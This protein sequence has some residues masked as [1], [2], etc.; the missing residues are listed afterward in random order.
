[1]NRTGELSTY[2]AR[3]LQGDKK[4]PWEKSKFW[5]GRYPSVRSCIIIILLRVT[6]MASAGNVG[7]PS[8][9]GQATVA[10]DPQGL[11]FTCEW[12]RCFL[13]RD[14]VLAG[15]VCGHC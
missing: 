12:A 2:R 9:C 1:M 11:V 14:K 8:S 13:G 7:S 15:D 6:H 3:L 5:L 10:F 4:R